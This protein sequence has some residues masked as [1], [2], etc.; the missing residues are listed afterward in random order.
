MLCHQVGLAAITLVPNGIKTY[1]CIKQETQK[2]EIAICPFNKFKHGKS[3][4]PHY[5]P[6]PNASRRP[7][8]NGNYSMGS[9][10][11]HFPF[12]L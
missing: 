3:G 11:T 8:Y 7:E 9:A 12:L 10:I 4:K 2:C 1:A 6:S 5:S